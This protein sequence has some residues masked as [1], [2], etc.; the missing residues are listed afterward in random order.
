MSD[1]SIQDFYAQQ[2]E[3]ARGPEPQQPSRRKR[4]RRRLKRIAIAAG[5]SLVVLVGG[6][7]GGSYLFVN[8]LASSVHRIPGI[9]AL[10]AKDQPSRSRGA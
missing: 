4:R 3:E 9:L 8:H 7:V 6:V 1:T 5:A 2:A 10:D